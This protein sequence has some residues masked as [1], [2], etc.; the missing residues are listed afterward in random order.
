MIR[1]SKSPP[2]EVFQPIT[3]ADLLA[4]PKYGDKLRR[5]MAGERVD[6]AACYTGHSVME[7]PH[8]FSF[9]HD[10]GNVVATPGMMGRCYNLQCKVGSETVPDRATAIWKLACTIWTLN[11]R[12]V[13]M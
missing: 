9:G 8:R 12:G 13:I 7:E 3:M 11:A 1:K 10:W 4:E 6:D 5:W 2:S